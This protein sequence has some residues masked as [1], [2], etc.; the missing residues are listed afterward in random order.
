MARSTSS[1]DAFESP[2]AAESS[3]PG[4]DVIRGNRPSPSTRSTF[5]RMAVVTMGSTM[6]GARSQSGTESSNQSGRP[7]YCVPSA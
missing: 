6:H 5:E 1:D 3:S 7:S 2:P 4:L